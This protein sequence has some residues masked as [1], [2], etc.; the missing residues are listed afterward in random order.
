[1][2]A[3]PKPVVLPDPYKGEGSWE[4]WEYHF[5]NVAAVNAWDDS[6]K[7]KWLKVRMTGRA[8]IAFQR[9]PDATKASYDLAM[10]ALKDRLEPATRK[11]RYQAELQTRHKKKTE[12]WADLADDLRLL[13]DKAYPQ[14]EEGAKE[15]L[16][17]NAY[18]AQLTNPQVAFG[19]KQKVP[20]TLDEAVTATLELESYLTP[21]PTT[22]AVAGVEAEEVKPKQEMTSVAAVTK[23]DTDNLGAL[24]QK[25]MNRM[26]KI[27]TA[28]SEREW[29]PR[30]QRPWND[31]RPPRAPR[32]ATRGSHLLDMW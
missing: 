7:L 13:S 8:Q 19:V 21:A 29:G 17:L 2:T 18:L 20:S 23:A 28:Q 4:Q 31:T 32:E 22:G 12:T 6:N 11:T 26:D 5:L 16:A 30:R 14:L 25:L 10:K 1:M 9:L 15:M 27:E 24:M 3:P